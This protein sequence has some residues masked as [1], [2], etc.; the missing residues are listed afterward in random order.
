MKKFKALCTR[1]FIDAF[2]GMA[3]GLFCT[4][5]AGLIIKQI[6]TLVGD[7]NAGRLLILIGNTASALTGAGIGAGIAKQLKAGNLVIFAAMIAGVVGGNSAQ[8]ISSGYALNTAALTAGT[9]AIRAGDPIGAYIAAL[10]AVELGIFLTGKTKLD[11]IVL[12]LSMMIITAAITVTI[13]PPII[14]LMAAIGSGINRAAELQPFIMG[15]II[16]VSVGVLLTLP[17]SS[18][19]ICISIGITGIAGGAAVVGC[20]CQM[21]GFAV[22]SFRE[23]KVSGLI[24]QGLGTSMLQIPNLMKKPVI[25]VPPIIASAICG[26]LSTL[27]FKLQCAPAGAGMGTSGLVGVITTYISSKNVVPGGTLISGIVL[28]E[29]VLPAVICL[30]VSEI[31]RKKQWI[32]FGDM[33]L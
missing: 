17:T 5:I 16:A 21:V 24:A 6:G 8:I 25:I 33:Q 32:K 2:T 26:P 18:A 29:F 3:H 20:C 7:N 10:I 4:L 22:Q 30:V 19:A 1:W 11:I 12:P 23:N 28:L 31:F 9:I 14:K 27:V 15:I 13:C